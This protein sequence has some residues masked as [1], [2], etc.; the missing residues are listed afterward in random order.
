MNKKEFIDW[1][2]S[3]GGKII[4]INAPKRYKTRLYEESEGLSEGGIKEITNT[5][6]HISEKGINSILNY[7]YTINNDPEDDLKEEIES[8]KLQ[9][10]K[11][12]NNNTNN[13][14]SQTQVSQNKTKTDKNEPLS[15]ETIWI[16]CGGGFGIYLF[17]H[18]EI[19]RAH[20]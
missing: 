5:S 20:V 14:T 7:D 11:A 18:D 17:D 6:N 1:I 16:G 12:S 2:K 3:L 9:L 15:V 4:K 8:L 13:D 10:K 19:G